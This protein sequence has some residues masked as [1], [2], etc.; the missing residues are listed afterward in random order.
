MSDINVDDQIRRTFFQ[1]GKCQAVS[2]GCFR[3][4][5]DSV[6]NPGTWMKSLQIYETFGLGLEFGVDCCPLQENPSKVADNRSCA[7][8]VFFDARIPAVERELPP[9]LAFGVWE[10]VL[11]FSVLCEGVPGFSY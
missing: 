2:S 1:T 3:K 5:L 8:P 6:F 9:A 4:G 11:S 10:E 7:N